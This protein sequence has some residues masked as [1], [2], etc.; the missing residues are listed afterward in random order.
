MKNTKGLAEYNYQKAESCKKRVISAIEQCKEE[1]DISITRV[2]EIACVNRSYFT[3]HPEMRKALDE[4]IGI[5]NRKVK[6]R[7]QNSDSHA[8]IEKALYTENT[9]P[10]RKLASL[11]E[12][13]KYKEMYH[14]KCDEVDE[15][16]KALENAT[17]ENGLL[18]F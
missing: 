10:K 12:F 7:K 18:D 11:E 4:A 17:L 2:C 13:E 9:I 14:A 6:K 5:V 15:L 8:V 1:K 3:K 16:K